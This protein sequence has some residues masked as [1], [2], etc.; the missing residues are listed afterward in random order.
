MRGRVAGLAAA[1]TVAGYA[2]AKADVGTWNPSGAL[3]PL[4]TAATAPAFSFDQLKTADFTRITLS[5]SGPTLNF[6]ESG[7]L[8]ITQASLTGHVPQIYTPTGLGTNY[9]LYMTFT[10]AGTTT[11]PNFSVPQ[12]S[13]TGTFTSLTYHLFGIAG[14][15]NFTPPGTAA[16]EPSPIA[17]STLLGSGSLIDGL[18]STNVIQVTANAAHSNCSPGTFGLPGPGLCLQIGPAATPLDLSLTP[19]PGQPGFFV[20]PNS[21]ISITLA[22]S[23]TNDFPNVTL[24]SSTD[25]SVNNGGGTLAPVVPTAVPVPEPVSLAVLGAGLAGMG[26]MRRRKHN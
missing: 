23:F 20:S 7:F 14:P 24:I 26:L 13:S 1:L 22:S 19:N 17:G 3:P 12:S 6:Q 10:A 4:G 2:G 15:E 11:G 18:T 5:G 16:G 9:T 8:D 21:T 25:I